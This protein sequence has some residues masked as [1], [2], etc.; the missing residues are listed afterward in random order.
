MIIL[1]HLCVLITL[2]ITSIVL[3]NKLSK[4]NKLIILLEDKVDEYLKSIE[5]LND[6]IDTLTSKSSIPINNLE[7][8]LKSKTF[9]RLKQ[10]KY[11]FTKTIEFK[12][13]IIYRVELIRYNVHTCVIELGVVNDLYTKGSPR[14]ISSFELNNDNITIEK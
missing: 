8:F 3:Y 10:N 4:K 1:F 6:T 13:P 12:D 14:Y 11:K 2:I 9:K 5:T 7:T